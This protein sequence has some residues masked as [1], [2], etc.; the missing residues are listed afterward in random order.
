MSRRQ[1]RLRSG[2]LPIVVSG[3]LVAAKAVTGFA[4]G[5]LAVLASAL[6]SLLDF[7][8]STINLFSI[9]KAQEPP[10][11]EHPFGHG[12][13]ESIAALLE[14]LLIAASGLYLALQGL[15]HLVRPR[16]LGSYELGA[17][18]MLA[19]LL[20]SLWVSRTLERRA[21]ETGSRLLRTD[22]LN[23]A[24]D[25]WTSLGVLLGLGLQA[26]TG[27]PWI[28]PALS[29]AIAL[30]ILWQ[31][32]PVLGGAVDE[33]MDRELG[34]E[35]R[36]EIESVV[37]GHAP[38]IIDFHRLRTRRAGPQKTIDVHVV[39]CKER[40]FE[41]AHALANSLEQALRERIP[42]ADVLVHAD[43][44]SSA[45]VRCPGPHRDRPGSAGRRGRPEL[46]YYE[47]VEEL[48][49]KLRATMPREAREI[50]LE[51]FNGAYA[52][53]GSPEEAAAAALRRLAPAYALEGGRWVEVRG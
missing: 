19:S 22:S 40:P 12:K 53:T 42:N 1:S 28:D 46:V 10:D 18:V 34:G 23:Y 15:R 13:A 3:L 37:Q 25:V 48:P 44:C 45:P 41:E 24:S 2:I 31:V 5:S 29:V 20:A 47:S 39:I 8:V 35:E 16:A 26:F 49:S 17:L 9:R 11:Q 4:I 50:Y 27:A 6:D 33:L 32:R 38:E 14:G 30:W 36:A 52:T 43:P 21:R 51:A 7:G